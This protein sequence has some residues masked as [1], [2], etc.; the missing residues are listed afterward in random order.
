[1]CNPEDIEVIVSFKTPDGKAFDNL[2]DALSHKPA[3]LYQM[4]CEDDGGIFKTDNP[5]EA[6]YVYLPNADAVDTFIRDSNLADT[7]TEGI[8]R[9]GWYQWDGYN[10]CYHAMSNAI[11]RIILAM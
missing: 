7:A 11:G 6:F 8:D 5:E 3:P 1:M 2:Q 4:W 10:L 9:A